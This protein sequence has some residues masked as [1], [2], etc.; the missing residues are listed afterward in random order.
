MI[1]DYYL[2]VFVIFLNFYIV[3]WL[4]FWL[5]VWINFVGYLLLGIY[6]FV[7]EIKLLFFMSDER[8]LGKR[9]FKV[10]FGWWRD[11]VLLVD[12][13]DCCWFLYYCLMF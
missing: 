1:E 4:G 5:V 12:S 7:D 3:D 8:K 11:S 13:V 6:F 9:E 10:G 2:I